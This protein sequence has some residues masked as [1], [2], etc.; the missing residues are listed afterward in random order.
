MPGPSDSSK[1][2]RISRSMVGRR[3]RRSS[4][5]GGRT[6]AVATAGRS[7][8]KSAQSRIAIGAATT[9]IMPMAGMLAALPSVIAPWVNLPSRSRMSEPMTARPR[10]QP[11]DART[12]VVGDGQHARPS[13]GAERQHRDAEVAD[14]HPQDQIAAADMPLRQQDLVE[15]EHQRSARRG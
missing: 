9:R 5:P 12:L 14:Q 13:R 1:S 3:D 4:S 2:A 15:P 7:G 11:I 10:V 8:V 6:L